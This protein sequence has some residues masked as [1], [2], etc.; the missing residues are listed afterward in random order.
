MALDDARRRPLGVVPTGAV[1]HGGK[2]SRL[3][4]IIRTKQERN[5]LVGCVCSNSET[6]VDEVIIPGSTGDERIYTRPTSVSEYFPPACCA[7]RCTIKS[8][9]IMRRCMYMGGPVRSKEPM[10]AYRL[11]S[12]DY[13]DNSM[14]P[15]GLLDASAGNMAFCG[16]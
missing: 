9:N 2:Y 12:V 6:T 11:R 8:R 7:H 14:L 3:V 10:Y 4:Y 16:E 1:V 5:R 15:V 13:I